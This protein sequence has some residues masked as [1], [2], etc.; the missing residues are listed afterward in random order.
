MAE[1]KELSDNE[2]LERLSQLINGCEGEAEEREFK[3][4]LDTVPVDLVNCQ[5]VA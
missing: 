4:L 3:E 5:S 1:K 2:K